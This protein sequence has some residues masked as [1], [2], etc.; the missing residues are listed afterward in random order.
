MAS[1]TNL[2]EKTPTTDELLTHIK[3]LQALVHLANHNYVSTQITNQL[4]KKDLSFEYKMELAK[5][6]YEILK[7]NLL[8][9]HIFEKISK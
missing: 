8:A 5:N 1:E 9:E 6:T 3:H 7:T 2:T 4:A